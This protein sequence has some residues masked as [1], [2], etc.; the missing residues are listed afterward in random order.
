LAYLALWPLLGTLDGLFAVLRFLGSDGGRL[1]STGVPLGALSLARAVVITPIA[2]EL[3]F[4]GA[5]YGWLRRRWPAWAAITLTAVAFAA[6][7]G[8]AMLLPYV[9]IFGLVTDW[10]RERTGSVAAGTVAHVLNNGLLVFAT[11]LLTGWTA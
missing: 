7:H 2:E 3:L 9:V 4:R 10:L 11:F 8:S 1:A 5:L 6:V